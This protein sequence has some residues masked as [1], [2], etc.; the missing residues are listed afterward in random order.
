MTAP[1]APGAPTGRIPLTELQPPAIPKLPPE[2]WMLAAITLERSV[3]AREW[4]KLEPVAAYLREH[5]KL[6]DRVAEDEHRRALRE[7]ERGGPVR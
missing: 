7:L 1:T 2:D 5:A 3:S 4:A 6:A